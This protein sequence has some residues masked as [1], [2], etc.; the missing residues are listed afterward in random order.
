MDGSDVLMLIFAAII[1]ILAFTG[2]ISIIEYVPSSHYI[3]TGTCYVCGVEKK[4]TCDYKDVKITKGNKI[5]N[6]YVV[7][8]DCIIDL[9][10]KIK[11]DTPEEKKKDD[12]SK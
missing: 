2:L 7:C 4:N 11:K 5:V 10:K 12:Q 8:D 3:S 6:T 1:A 9:C